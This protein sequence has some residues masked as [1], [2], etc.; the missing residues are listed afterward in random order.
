MRHSKMIGYVVGCVGVLTVGAALAKDPEQ[1]AGPAPAGCNDSQR[2][3]SHVLRFCGAR[4]YWIKVATVRSTTSGAPG[5]GDWGS[6][7]STSFGATGA[8]M[9]GFTHQ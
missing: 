4:H 2:G 3:R 9:N 7:G 5:T 6:A 8:S 1:T